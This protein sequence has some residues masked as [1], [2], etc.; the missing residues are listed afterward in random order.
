MLCNFDGPYAQWYDCRGLVFHGSQVVSWPG[1]IWPQVALL[2][3]DS[4]ILENGRVI[5]LCFQSSSISQSSMPTSQSQVQADASRG[6]YPSLRWRKELLVLQIVRYI[7][8]FV[9]ILLEMLIDAC[10]KINVSKKNV[11]SYKQ[12]ISDV[13]LACQCHKY[14]TKDLWTKFCRSIRQLSPFQW[15][16]QHL[17][18]SLGK[19]PVANHLPSPACQSANSI[20]SFNQQNLPQIC[21][22]FVLKHIF[23]I[24]A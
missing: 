2:F 21:F 24:G 20:G 14:S 22:W 7:V 18:D 6:V 15:Q 3:L 19:S 23:P 4:N 5:Y 12:S 13:I 17:T 8:I 1:D 16:K 11:W 10:N 9:N